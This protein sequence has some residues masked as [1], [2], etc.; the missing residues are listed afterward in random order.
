M[1]RNKYRISSISG[2]SYKMR[3]GSQIQKQQCDYVVR[4]HRLSLATWQDL[5]DGVLPSAALLE[6][7]HASLFL[8]KLKKGEMVRKKSTGVNIQGFY[9]VW[10][11]GWPHHGQ[12][13][14]FTF[15]WTQLGTLELGRTARAFQARHWGT[16]T[17]CLMCC[18][19]GKPQK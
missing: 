13:R 19:V 2:F 14:R 12:R 1:I 18:K 15:L 4:A 7:H 11:V 8:I 5:Q 16:H 17:L 10:P 6:H 3:L 9:N